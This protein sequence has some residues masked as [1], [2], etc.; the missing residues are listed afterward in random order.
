VVDE[1][2][3]GDE[4]RT[5]LSP[6]KEKC[7]ETKIIC[8]KR[9]FSQPKESQRPKNFS[10][11]RGCRSRRRRSKMALGE[12]TRWRRAG[13]KMGGPVGAKVFTVKERRFL[14]ESGVA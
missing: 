14:A 8:G 10:Q 7:T 9:A 13:L 5:A 3:R 2:W 6:K 4:I 12:R 1:G 11:P